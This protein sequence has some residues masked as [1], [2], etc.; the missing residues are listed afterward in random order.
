[1]LLGEHALAL[2]PPSSQT[3]RVA[4]HFQTAGGRRG[5]TMMF[6]TRLFRNRATSEDIAAVRTG[7]AVRDNDLLTRAEREMQAG[8]K[9]VSGARPMPP[10]LKED[11][12]AS[13]RAARNWP[14]NISLTWEW[15]LES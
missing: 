4:L 7:P 1:M 2:F 9:I 8:A 12:P 14:P 3:V 5:R 6:F 10:F 11:E 15:P 13:L